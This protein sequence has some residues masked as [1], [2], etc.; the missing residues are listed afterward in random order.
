[1]GRQDGDEEEV[2]RRS[3]LEADLIFRASDTRP[4]FHPG[5]QIFRAR[6]K[7]EQ[8]EEH[9]GQESKQLLLPPPPHT[10]SIRTISFDPRS[11]GSPQ[12]GPQPTPQPT[13]QTL[14]HTAF[15]GQAAP[16]GASD[17]VLGEERG[18]SRHGELRVDVAQAT[19]YG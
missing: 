10:L 2:P 9:R 7:G 16:V 3:G 13:A 15:F 8:Q 11:S 17:G 19:G 12:A 5:D 18:G 14:I 1:M 4:I 6:G